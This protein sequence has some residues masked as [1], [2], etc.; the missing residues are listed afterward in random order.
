MGIA[1][2]M[3]RLLLDE[4]SRRPFSGRVLQ[5]GRQHLFFGMQEL[6][7]W[8]SVHNVQLRDTP[9]Q[10]SHLQEHACNGYI[11]DTTFFTALGFSCVESM[12]VSDYENCTHVHDLNR[13]VPEN[14]YGRY[15]V[16]FDGGTVEHVFDTPSCL[17]NIHAMLK[18]GG[19]I[20]HGSPSTNHVDHG[21][22][23]FSPVLFYDYYDANNYKI[24]Q[25]LLIF[26][27]QQHDKD[28]WKIVTYEPGVLDHLSFG[29]FDRGFMLAI[30]LIARKTA[31]STCV[32]VPQQGE[33]RR[34]HGAH[35]NAPQSKLYAEW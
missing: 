5:L 16:I 24:E 15:D 27:T 9:V 7:T 26:H 10:F 13:P 22:Y 34:R 18:V 17:R 20:I 32:Q 31:N 25:S 4:H 19:R 21:Y 30:C 14:L 35:N 6:A 23:M 8:A 28:L 1:R 2:G 29:G 3:A 12:D 33:Y 11:D